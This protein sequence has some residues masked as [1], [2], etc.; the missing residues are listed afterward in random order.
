MDE[1]GE[2]IV[3]GLHHVEEHSEVVVEC[4]GTGN[5]YWTSSTG[6]EISQ[7]WSDDIYQSYDHTR[8]ALALVFHNFTSNYVATYT[9]TTDLVNVYTAGPISHS[10][11]ITNGEVDNG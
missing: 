2:Q 11:L 5:L 8:D 6:F 3:G 7:N 10:L 1:R 4:L 9:C